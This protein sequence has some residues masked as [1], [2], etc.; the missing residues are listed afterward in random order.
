MLNLVS[1]IG[2]NK[3]AQIVEEVIVLNQVPCIYYLV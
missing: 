1:M 2:A 3:K